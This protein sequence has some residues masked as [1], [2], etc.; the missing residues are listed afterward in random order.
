[1]YRHHK[2]CLLAFDSF[3]DKDGHEDRERTTFY[4][5]NEYVYSLVK[6]H[7]QYFYPVGSVNPYREDALDELEKCARNGVSII[8]W[9]VRL[10]MHRVWLLGYRLRVHVFKHALQES[11][12]PVVERFYRESMCVLI[13]PYRYM[14]M[15]VWCPCHNWFVFAPAQLHGDWS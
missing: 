2:L 1:M 5:P 12:T 10:L 14:Y 11:Y 6:D 9:L 15:W 8:K 4:I 7:D 13:F 3:Y